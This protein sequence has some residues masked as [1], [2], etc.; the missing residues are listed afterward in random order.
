MK[1]YGFVIFALLIVGIFLFTALIRNKYVKPYWHNLLLKMPI[2]GRLISYGQLAR[3]SRNLGTLI[4]SG[5]PAPHGMEITANTL[6]NLRFRNDLLEITKL[7]T[8]GKN[9]GE[10]MASR[11][12]SEFPP[13]VSRMI[14]VGEKTGKLDETLIY[15][16]EFYEEEVDDVSRN[17]STILEPV[18]LITIGL[19]VGFVALSIISPI[20]QLTGSIRN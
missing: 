8:R 19:V 6:T 5:V 17:L 10:S 3:F 12:F 9:I 20:Y 2:V 1:N 14:T 15:L 13:L 7:L 18:L 16:G 11:D 4:K